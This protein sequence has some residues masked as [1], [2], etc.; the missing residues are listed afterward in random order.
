[1]ML[2]RCGVHG[3]GKVESDP[4]RLQETGVPPYERYVVQGVR[5]SAMQR[6]ATILQPVE[7]SR[8]SKLTF[9][10]AADP[11][12]VVGR[13]LLRS[14]PALPARN[15]WRCLLLPRDESVLPAQPQ[16]A[17]QVSPR[18]CLRYT[19]GPLSAATRFLLLLRLPSPGSLLLLPQ[20]GEWSTMWG[21]RRRARICLPALLELPA[22]LSVL[23]T[24]RRCRRPADRSRTL[25]SRQAVVGT[26]I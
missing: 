19:A 24:I 2:L 5:L 13:P 6:P 20:W 9:R 8:P 21:R 22:A 16:R 17:L 15:G 26:M 10:L 1:M 7:R 12:S 11:P 18:W 14:P 23:R 4:P 3:A 25:P